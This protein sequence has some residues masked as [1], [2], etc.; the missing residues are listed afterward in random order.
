MTAFY[1]SFVLLALM[2][3]AAVVYAKR[4]P[5]GTPL[6][7]GE[8][9]VGAVY[10]YAVMF[11]AYGVFPHQ[12]LNW[13]DSDLKWRRD[14]TGIPLG[15]FQEVANKN[16]E[17]HWYSYESNSL[18]PH[19]ITFFGRGRVTLSKE[20]IRD[21]LAAGIYIVLLGGQ[22]ALWSWWNKRG[23]KAA[24]KAVEPSSAYGRPLVRK[25]QA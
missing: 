10:A 24:T 1:S 9:M 19:G 13:A 25:A 16:W 12:W 7:W 3:A 11:V 8:A 2:V 5:A 6:T 14:A 20:S 22:I 21:A 17:N 23:K 15:I 18:W 4:R